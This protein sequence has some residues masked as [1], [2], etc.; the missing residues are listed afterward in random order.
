[1]DRKEAIKI[2]KEVL[3]AC[4]DTI[5]GSWVA[6]MLPDADDV[7]SKDYQLHIKAQINELNR[8]CVKRVLNK[9]GLEL[10]KSK[11]QQ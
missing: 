6:L 8:C 5:D 2:L 10:E 11:R 7:L 9:H 4:G 1:M 3:S